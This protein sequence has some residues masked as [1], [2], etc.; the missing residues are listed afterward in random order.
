MDAVLHTRAGFH[1]ELLRRRGILERCW[2]TAQDRDGSL[3][4]GIVGSMRSA[5]NGAADCQGL[6]PCRFVIGTTT[7]P[8]FVELFCSA[9]DD[10][11]LG[12]TL[13]TIIA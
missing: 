1:A 8:Q 5:L 12:K 11:D 4:P 13:P 9:F 3:A 10:R 6:L 7:D 2:A